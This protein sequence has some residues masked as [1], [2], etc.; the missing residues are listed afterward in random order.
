MD[1]RKKKRI[2]FRDDGFMSTGQIKAEEL[3][4][5]RETVGQFERERKFQAAIEVTEAM[6][7]KDPYHPEVLVKLAGLYAKV[8]NKE[9]HDR[10]FRR[11]VYR[12]ANSKVNDETEKLFIRLS[13]T[14]P[15]YQ[16]S[17]AD[18][19]RELQAGMEMIES[20]LTDYFPNRDPWERERNIGTRTV[21]SF[22]SEFLS[23]ARCYLRWGSSPEEA[24]RKIKEKLAEREEQYRALKRRRLADLDRMGI[25][26]VL[27]GP[28]GKQ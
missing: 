20:F 3:E 25:H 23:D 13:V 17:F 10:Y 6:L 9:M 18:A 4:E 24:L 5:F 12:L 15:G 7:R 28:G 11:A 22:R 8:C 21:E 26:Y 2:S 1:L 19:I 16:M 27:I 14:R